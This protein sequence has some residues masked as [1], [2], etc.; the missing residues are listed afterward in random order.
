MG[1]VA[2]DLEWA[3]SE[4]GRF[5]GVL[6]IVRTG[7]TPLTGQDHPAPSDVPVLGTR[8]APL[9][10]KMILKMLKMPSRALAYLLIY[11]FAS[12]TTLPLHT[13]GS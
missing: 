12:V 3:T 11:L 1:T 6:S 8:P 2:R 5:K 9:F 4:R 10:L 7:K 13:L